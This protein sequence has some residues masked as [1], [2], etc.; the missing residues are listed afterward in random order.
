M[1]NKTDTLQVPEEILDA[2][3]LLQEEIVG[4]LIQR[5]LLGEY[6]LRRSLCHAQAEV[7][8]LI[9]ESGYS[10]GVTLDDHKVYV[11]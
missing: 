6:N 7:N 8:S 5:K 9:E 2:K 10:L 11:V 4:L 1:S 3:D